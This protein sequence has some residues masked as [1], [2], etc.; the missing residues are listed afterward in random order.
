MTGSYILRGCWVH[1]FGSAKQEDS[2]VFDREIDGIT[3]QC[4]ELTRPC[5]WR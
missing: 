2:G 1:D 3:E 4:C 5:L